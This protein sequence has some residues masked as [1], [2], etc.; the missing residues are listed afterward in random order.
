MP[1][2]YFGLPTRSSTC[3]SKRQTMQAPKHI[4]IIIMKWKDATP[5]TLLR[6]TSIAMTL[7]KGCS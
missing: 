4:L 5:N 6:M 7:A 2:H 1:C 3:P